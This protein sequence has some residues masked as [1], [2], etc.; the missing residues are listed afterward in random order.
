MARNLVQS[1][2]RRER[3]LRPEDVA[4][5]FDVCK[6][7]VIGW[8]TSGRLPFV[9]TPTGHYRFRPAD[10]DAMVDEPVEVA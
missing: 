7:T 5:V 3:L 4:D 9:R 8:A 1:R 6:R 2:P 10:V